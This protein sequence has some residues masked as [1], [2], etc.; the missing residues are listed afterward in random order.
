M[1]RRE[2]VKWITPVV[3][4]VTLPAHAQ[5]SVTITRKPPPKKPCEEIIADFESEYRLLKD[6]PEAT[7]EEIREARI[8]WI[9]SKE[10]RPEDR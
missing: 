5:T 7:E 2:I 10:C 6:D 3:M 8:A 1:K 9:R 4:G